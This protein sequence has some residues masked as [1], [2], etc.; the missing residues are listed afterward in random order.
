MKLLTL[1]VH[2]DL[3]ETLAD[4]LRALPGV[5][6]F[7]FARIESH[8]AQELGDASFSTRDRV[9]GYTPHVRVDLILEDAQVAAVLAAL[10]ADDSGVA[11]RGRYWVT[12]V[13]TEGTL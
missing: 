11:G 1:I 7:S 5:S 12:E 4:T 13:E 3:E 2:A 10:R 6:T 8:D 9:A